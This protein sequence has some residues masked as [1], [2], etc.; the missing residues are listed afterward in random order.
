MGAEIVNEV[1]DGVGWVTMSNPARRNA[2]STAML[3][4]LAA[5]VREFDETGAVRTIVLRGAGETFTAGADISE[6]AAHHDATGARETWER[7]LTGLFETLSG[8]TTPLIAMIQGHCFGAGMALALSADIRIAAEG[9]RFAIP[10]ARLGIGYPYALTQTLVHAVGPAN[11]SEMLFTARAYTDSEALNAGLITRLA[12]AAELEDDVLRTASAIAANAPLAVR[13]AKASIK[14]AAHPALAARAQQLIAETT[15]SYDEF[16][17]QR[18]F[19]ERRPP[20]FE[21]R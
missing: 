12:P 3:G 10:A 5:V 21:G 17:G 19:M 11:A 1:R 4:S 8:L 20:A 6:F 14:A 18:A 7:T 16:E 9:S 13:A 15:G 2:L